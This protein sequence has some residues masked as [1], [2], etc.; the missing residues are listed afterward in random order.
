M[1]A[2]RTDVICQAMQELLE[3]SGVALCEVYGV[4]CK[5]KASMKE[6]GLILHV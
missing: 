5:V 2:K 1:L 4:G 6:G 3:V